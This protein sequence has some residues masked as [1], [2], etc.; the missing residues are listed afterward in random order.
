MTPG[1]RT[2]RAEAERSWSLRE[3]QGRSSS[4]SAGVGVT[5][6][7][8]L[9]TDL[10]AWARLQRRVDLLPAL[11]PGCHHASLT[12]VTA[13]R[14]RVRVA[15]DRS[16]RRADELQDEL[17]DGPSLQAVR[18]SHSVLSPDLRTETRWVDWC[19]AALD[20]L[21]VAAVLAVLLLPTLQPLTTLNLYSGTLEGLSSVDL[22]H[23]HRFTGPLAGAVLDPGAGADRLGPAA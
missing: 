17:A 2:R 4:D 20:E 7:G 10:D 14:L 18:T 19:S 12:T 23:L 15:T 3:G 6:V 1:A 21:G 8:W 22:A 5:S 9:P 16:A 11:V 13:G